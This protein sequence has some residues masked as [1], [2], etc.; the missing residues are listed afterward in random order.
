MSKLVISLFDHSG[1]WSS[2]FAADKR[3]QVVCVDLKLGQ[4]IL[5]WRPPRRAHVVL[6]APPCDDFAGCGARH[7]AAKDADGRTG[8][9]V[10]LLRR[11]L[12][13]IE[14][15]RPEV[16][17]IENPVGRLSRYW[18]RPQYL[19]H[20][21]EFAGY[22]PYPDEDR[23]TKKTCL[24]G[25]F[26]MPEKKPLEPV[27]YTGAGGKQ[28]SWMWANLGGKSERTKELRSITPLGFSNATYLANRGA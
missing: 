8:R 21:Y 1:N 11:T 28:G 23:Y 25:R 17:I 2:Y 26:Q 16:W 4:D 27:M 14:A 3:Y 18:G 22:S 5:T 12:S 13:I 7:W 10:S 20:P 19:F 15:V 9:S 6:A 24:W